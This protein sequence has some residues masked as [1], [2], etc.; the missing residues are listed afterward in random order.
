MQVNFTIYILFFYFSRFL[1][2]L[3]LPIYLKKLCVKGFEKLHKGPVL[4]ASNHSGSFFDAVVIGSIMTQ[5][6][7]TLTRG[8][9][10]KKKAAA[11]WLRQIK[12]IPVFRG[13][14]GRQYVKNHDITVK[15][16]YDA[17]KGGGAVIIFSE[18]VCVNEWNLRPLGK[19][20]ARMAY[21]T[22]YGD[23]P[24]KNMGVVP[25][26]V[27]YEHF[28]G[29]GKRVSLHFGE[30]IL[31]HDIKTDPQEY[32]RW[33]R[34][35]NEIL[36]R[37][38]SAEVWSIPADISKAERT[39]RLNALFGDCPLPPGGNAIQKVIGW[40][41]R[42]IH[43]PLYHFFERKTAKLTARS[44]FYDS[45]LFGLLMYLYPTIVVLLSLIAGLIFGWA[46]GLALFFILPLLAWFAARY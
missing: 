43:R 24:L 42:A 23:A 1:V 14:E 13:S 31:I 37:K 5:P 46:V 28:R 34:E 9:V 8:D 35:F 44:V 29:P 15:E 40:F 22:W 17:M 41:G 19:G 20:T 3:A 7:F 45:V 21:Q 32:E 6:I 11:F 38:M 16:G 2:R 27:N 26:G 25:T 36:E 4:L 18:G 39:Q 33:L 10:F 12:L 30:A